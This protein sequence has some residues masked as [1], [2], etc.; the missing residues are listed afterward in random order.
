MNVC[1][2]TMYYKN[3]K[4]RY[5]KS[6]SLDIKYVLNKNKMHEIKV[7]K[8]T[9]PDFVHVIYHGC[10]LFSSYLFTVTTHIIIKC[11]RFP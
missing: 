3:I 8:A 1:M 2:I 7:L 4:K 5:V 10:A 11:L 6:M 9:I